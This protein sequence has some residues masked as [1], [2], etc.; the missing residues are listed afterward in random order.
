MPPTMKKNI[1]ATPYMMP[2]FLWSTVNTHDRQPVVLTGR[3]KTPSDEPLRDEG[4]ART[5]RR[6]PAWS[7]DDGHAGSPYF[8]CEQVGD[9]LV[10]LVFGEVQVRHATVLAVDL[11]PLRDGVHR[12]L[13]RRVADPRRAARPRSK[14]SGVTP[15]RYSGAELLRAGARAACP[16]TSAVS[17]SNVAPANVVRVIRLVRFGAAPAIDVQVGV[18]RSPAVGSCRRFVRQTVDLVAA[19]AL[20]R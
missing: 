6:R 11:A 16:G 8:R 10:D 9:D 17:R 2:S 7:F 13:R 14:H 19:R 20:A 18:G 5:G 3:R 4:A 15:C 1:A 12:L